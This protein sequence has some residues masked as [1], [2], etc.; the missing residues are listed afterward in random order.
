LRDT[1]SLR[2]KLTW[3]HQKAESAWW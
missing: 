3:A 2:D 1:Q